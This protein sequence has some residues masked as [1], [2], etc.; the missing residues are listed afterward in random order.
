M[1]TKKFEDY[2]KVN[3]A[4]IPDLSEGYYLVNETFNIS[5]GGGWR[6]TFREGQVLKLEGDVLKRYNPLRK[7]WKIVSPPISG[8]EDFYLYGFRDGKAMYNKFKQNT[9]IITEK[10]ANKIIS[11]MVQEQVIKVRDFDRFVRQNGLRP[12][13][14]IKII[15]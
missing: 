8:K 6:I 4:S 12:N 10:E 3:E 14:E 5:P 1:K 2:N 7:D 13:Q 11:E 9:A 15:L